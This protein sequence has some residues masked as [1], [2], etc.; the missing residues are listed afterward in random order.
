MRYVTFVVIPNNPAEKWQLAPGQFLMD[1]S[2][3][4]GAGKH[5]LEFTHPK[6]RQKVRNGQKVVV[7]G[8]AF[9]VGSSREQAVMA[10]KGSVLFTMSCPIAADASQGPEC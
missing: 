8:K 1:M 10:L 4:E 6:F 3:D 2:S 7:A 9:G 5:V